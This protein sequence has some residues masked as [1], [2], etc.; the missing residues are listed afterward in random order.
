MQQVKVAD[1]QPLFQCWRGRYTQVTVCLRNDQ[2]PTKSELPAS[3]YWTERQ[4]DCPT[5]APS[6][7]ALLFELDYSDKR[8]LMDSGELRSEGFSKKTAFSYVA[9]EPLS[10]DK[11]ELYDLLEAALAYVPSTDVQLR[12]RMLAAC[13]KIQNL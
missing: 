13:T 9:L 7:G 1:L 12:A 8:K 6:D 3:F 10:K 5:D 2:R 4:G 11:Q